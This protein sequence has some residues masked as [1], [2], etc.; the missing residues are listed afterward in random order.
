MINRSKNKIFK[1]SAFSL[2]NELVKDLSTKTEIY[3]YAKSMRTIKICKDACLLHH[4]TLL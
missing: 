1:D 4:H 3:Q 2:Y